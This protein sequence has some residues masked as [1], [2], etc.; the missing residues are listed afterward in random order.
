MGSIGRIILRKHPTYSDFDVFGE[1]CNIRT[2]AAWLEVIKADEKFGVE[3]VPGVGL[4]TSYSS[5]RFHL[6][7]YYVNPQ[8]ELITV[9]D[10]LQNFLIPG[11]LY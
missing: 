1:S 10:E 4:S 6:L 8:S 3:M 7:G 11:V 2:I 9:L 5:G